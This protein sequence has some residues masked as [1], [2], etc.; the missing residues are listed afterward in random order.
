[1]RCIAASNLAFTCLV[2]SFE[3]AEKNGFP[4]YVALQPQYNLVV[5][6]KFETNYLPLVEKYGLSVFPYYSLATG[7]LTGK[8]RTQTDLGKSVRGGGVEKYLNEKGLG[9]L[10]ALDRVA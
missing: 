8:Y 9:V 10:A 7:F 2:E 4:K 1:M 5:R 6:T 3:L